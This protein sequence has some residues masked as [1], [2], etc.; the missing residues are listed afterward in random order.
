M[1]SSI[2]IIINQYFILVVLYHP[3]LEKLYNPFIKKILINQW[4]YD[5]S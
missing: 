4:R 1:L 3:I 5:I 2:R